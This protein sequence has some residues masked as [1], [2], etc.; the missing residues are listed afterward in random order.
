M[1]ALGAVDFRIYFYSFF[2]LSLHLVCGYYLGLCLCSVLLWKFADDLEM[3]PA[4]QIQQYTV[5]GWADAVP[6]TMHT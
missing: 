4:S 2:P 3:G 5:V 1:E 6:K